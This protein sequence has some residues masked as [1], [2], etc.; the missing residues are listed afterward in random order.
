MKKRQKLNKRFLRSCVGAS[1]SNEDEVS[2]CGTEVSPSNSGSGSG[3]PDSD[4]DKVLGG[5]GELRGHT[6]DSS[7]NGA[8]TSE[9]SSSGGS[10]S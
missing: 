5:I 7:S 3:M 8:G 2:A 10:D 1:D 6:S 4:S 9:S